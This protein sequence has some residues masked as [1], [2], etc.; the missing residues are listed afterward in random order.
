MENKES[1]NSLLAKWKNKESTDCQKTYSEIISQNKITNKGEF[2]VFFRFLLPD[3]RDA[4]AKRY[5]GRLIK[6][7][8]TVKE[9]LS[10]LEKEV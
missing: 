9:I 5:I 6:E 2:E 4:A 7:G 1:F 10:L 8:K 3:H